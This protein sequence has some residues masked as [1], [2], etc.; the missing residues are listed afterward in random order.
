M[1]GGN[2]A[3][4][5]PEAIDSA[6]AV[7][8]AGVGTRADVPNRGQVVIF[9]YEHTPRVATTFDVT[10]HLPDFGLVTYRDG[11]GDGDS[12]D[13]SGVPG[14]LREI[15]KARSRLLTWRMLR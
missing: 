8:A 9:P 11:D 10:F 14:A 5:V 15:G 7:P 3:G 13:A 12:G 2:I 1:L 4:A 6:N